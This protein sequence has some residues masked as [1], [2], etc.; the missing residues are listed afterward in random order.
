MLGEAI[1]YTDLEFRAAR[2][3]QPPRLVFLLEEPACPPGLGDAEESQ[4]IG[5]PYA[6]C[7]MPD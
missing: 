1:S 6:G 7:A 2:D 5:V 3:G 4:A